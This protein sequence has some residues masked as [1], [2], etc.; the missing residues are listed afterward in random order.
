M[1]SKSKTTDSRKTS[2]LAICLRASASLDWEPTNKEREMQNPEPPTSRIATFLLVDDDEFSVEALREMLQDDGPVHIETAT[3]GQLALQALA[4]MKE[5]PDMLICDLFMPEMDGI[6]IMAQLARQHY[7]GAIVLV[8]GRN[9]EY[10][11]IAR[12]IA[13]RNGL[14]V[15]GVLAKPLNRDLLLEA[16]A[17]GRSMVSDGQEA[18]G[19][20]DEA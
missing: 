17:C 12:L 2:Q 3:N 13:I 11:A 9:I 20:Q 19:C 15:I 10:L 1:R 5:V 8:S 18:P 14:N 4:S 7:P 16:F 6:D